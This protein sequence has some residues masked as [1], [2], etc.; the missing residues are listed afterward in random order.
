MG[1]YGKLREEF[2]N[3]SVYTTAR[4]ARRVRWVGIVA[5]IVEK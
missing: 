5:C 1:G 4:K 3:L 2:H